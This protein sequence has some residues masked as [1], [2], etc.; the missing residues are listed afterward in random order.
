MYT[1]HLCLKL[2][3]SRK[4]GVIF[5]RY[6]VKRTHGRTNGR[7][8]QNNRRQRHKNHEIHFKLQYVYKSYVGAFDC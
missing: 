5:V 6:G 2:Y 8:D 4:I 7:T 1:I 3:Q